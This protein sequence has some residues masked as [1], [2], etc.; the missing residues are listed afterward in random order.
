MTPTNTNTK[1]KTKTRTKTNTKIKLSEDD[2]DEVEEG[3]ADK[4]GEGWMGGWTSEDTLGWQPGLQGLHIDDRHNP[5]N[6]HHNLYNNQNYS[7]D[8]DHYSCKNTPAYI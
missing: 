6:I 7:C 1:T 3:K 2:D 4:R 8:I 5:F